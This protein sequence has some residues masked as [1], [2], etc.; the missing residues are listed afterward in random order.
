MPHRCCRKLIG[1]AGRKRRTL[2]HPEYDDPVKCHDPV[3]GPTRRFYIRALPEKR[4]GFIE[5]QEYILV[6]CPA[7]DLSE[8][9]LGLANILA[10]HAGINR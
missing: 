1:K 5:K 8:I 4:I 7:E 6:F 9:L 10:Y 3:F 2:T